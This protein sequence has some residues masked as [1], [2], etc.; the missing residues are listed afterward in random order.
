MRYYISKVIGVLVG[1]PIAIAAWLSSVFGLDIFFLFDG[2]IGF[3]GFF[4]GYLPTQRLVSR[5]F[6]KENGLSRKEYRYIRRQ[7]EQSQHKSKRIFKS[8]INV[9]SVKDFRTVNDIY[10]LTRT[11]NQI[12]AK[13]PY[14]FYKVE[15]Y[16]YSHIENATNL[17]DNYMRLSRISNK[18]KDEKQTLEQTRITLHEIKRTLVADLKRLNED[19]YSQLEVEIELNNLEQKRNRTKTKDIQEQFDKQENPKEM[20]RK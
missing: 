6:L 17:I 7:L 13:R 16:F 8:F 14:K 18:S 15:S 19:D 2:L 1:I 20:E 11:I 10:R 4:V 5:S 12:V 9:R 3:L